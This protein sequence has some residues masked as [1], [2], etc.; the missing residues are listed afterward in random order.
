MLSLTNEGRIY[1]RKKDSLF[2]KRCWKNWTDMCKR[3]KLEIKWTKDLNVRLETIKVIEENI[4]S[5]LFDVNHS[6]I[7]SDPPPR[8]MEKKKVAFYL[9]LKFLT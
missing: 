7:L 9:K 5:T 3:M 4:V 1:N 6:K 2:N 8:Q